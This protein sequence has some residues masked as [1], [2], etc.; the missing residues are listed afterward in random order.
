MLCTTYSVFVGSGETAI[1]RADLP[2]ISGADA[3]EPP[4]ALVPSGVPH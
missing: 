4:F 3:G 1:A 2:C